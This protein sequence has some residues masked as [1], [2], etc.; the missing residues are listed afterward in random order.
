MP[1]PPKGPAAKTTGKN[2]P[3][4][5][6]TERTPAEAPPPVDAGPAK[7]SAP[8]WPIA[9]RNAFPVVGIGASAGG[10][11]ALEAFFQALPAGSGM[12]FV[13]VTHT[14][15]SHTGLLPDIIE[16]QTHDT[17]RLI[18]D[19]MPVQPDTIYMPPSDRNAVIE[20]DIFRLQKR[21][22]RDE[23]PM[24]VDLFLKHLARTR[25]AQAACVIL[26]GTGS[27]GTHGLRAVK[28]RDGLTMAQSPDS[29]RHAG[30]P[31]SAI[32]TGLVDVVTL[33]D[34][35]PERL[36]RYFEHPAAGHPPPADAQ[37]EA[38]DRI[39]ALRA[40]E[41]TRAGQ[42][43]KNIVADVDRKRLERFF[44]P[45]DSGYRI[46]RA[47]REPVIFAEQNVLRDPPF[48]DLDLLIYLKTEAQDR[49]I[50]LFHHVLRPNGILFLGNS[51][52]IGRFPDLFEPLSKSF[53]IFRKRKRSVSTPVHFP[54]GKIVSAATASPDGQRRDAARQAPA[55]LDKAV[56]TLLIESFLPACMVVGAA[57]EVLFTRGR[58]GK[59]LELAPLAAGVLE[60]LTPRE[61]EVQSKD[62]DWYRMS[63]MV[64]RKNDHLIEGIVI[65]FIDINAQKEAQ[66]K[67]LAAKEREV[68]AARRFSDSIVATVRESLLV[69]DDRMQVHTA[70]DRYDTGFQ[71]TPEETEGACLFD[72]GNGQWDIP[73]LRNRLS[74]VARK[75]QI[76]NDYKVALHLPKIGERQL[77]LN[78]RHLQEEDPAGTKILLA[79]EDITPGSPS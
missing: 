26:S 14:D 34:Q 53:S 67:L 75:H 10:L 68:A 38:I 37:A 40:I 22:A 63:C 79:I 13:V 72:L 66:A 9:A 24:P 3:R 54:N 62:G 28:A 16:R 69:L 25:G 60:T 27:D 59:Y 71:V 2:G 20:G 19:G 18:E 76:F 11:Q 32:A 49:L 39:L 61:A 23:V 43:L 6:K 33:P 77:L 65:T 5:R 35:M 46:L 36:I 56:D 74:E 42:Y 4:H 7:P 29:A 44:S 12:A 45:V 30:M 52:T 48:S 73:E 47:I 31:A 78:A 58:S 15:P 55:S 41:Q 17:V 51:E 1:S 57:G 21:P 70:N 64:H 8:D 50:P